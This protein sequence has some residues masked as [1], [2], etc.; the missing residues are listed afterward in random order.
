MSELGVDVYY[1][2]SMP[3]VVPERLEKFADLGVKAFVIEGYHSGTLHACGDEHPQD[4][5]YN[6]VPFLERMRDRRIPVFLIF[7]EFFGDLDNKI[8]YKPF[9]EGRPGGY[10]T[11]NRIIKAGI[12]PLRANWQQAPAVWARLEEIIRQ[13][14]DYDDIIAQMYSSFPF[15]A[16]LGEMQAATYE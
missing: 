9:D 6:F 13:T 8:G 10:E 5:K 7:G 11:T 12:V 14:S 1:E 2:I 4:C 16:S 3:G 15:K